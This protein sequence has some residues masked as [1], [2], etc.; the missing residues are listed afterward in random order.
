[1]TNIVLRKCIK[2]NGKVFSDQ[3]G[4]SLKVLNKGKMHICVMYYQ[5]SNTFLTE[6]SK[7][8][9]EH[10]IVRA[11]IKFQIYLKARG[12]HLMFQA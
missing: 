11:Q 7:S 3:A 1:M 5:D 2:I 9:L 6:A 10:D 12:L 4:R 8:R